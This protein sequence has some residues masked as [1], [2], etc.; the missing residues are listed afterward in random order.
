[1]DTLPPTD[2]SCAICSKQCLLECLKCYKCK[3]YIHADCSNLP[4]YAIVNFFKTRCQYT[5]ENCTK[6]QLGD[7][8][9]RLFAQVYSLLENEKEAKLKLQLELEGAEANTDTNGDVDLTN[10]EGERV[11]E[12]D[13]YQTKQQTNRAIPKATKENTNK[14]PTTNQRKDQVCYYYKQNKCKYGLRGWNCPYAHPKLCNKFKVNG[15]DPVRGCKKGKDCKYLHPSICIG[16]ERRREC[17]NVEC[18]KLHLK[19]TRRYPPS[20]QYPPGDHVTAAQTNQHTGPDKQPLANKNILHLP[21][22]PYNAWVNEPPHNQRTE[23]FLFQQIQQMQQ[24]QQQILQ[25]LKTIPWQ[26]GPTH[27]PQGFQ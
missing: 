9:D 2:S 15:Y 8:C 17:F 7:G 21:R 24:T 23:S 26:G 5:C 12:S 16:S 13:E 10:K 6:K 4:P 20:P 18:K 25:M 11:S 3:G 1:M 14:K 22:Q 19:G 27:S